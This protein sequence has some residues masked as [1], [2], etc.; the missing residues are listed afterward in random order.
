MEHYNIDC[1]VFKR[2][3][4]EIIAGKKPETKQEPKE[5]QEQILSKEGDVKNMIRMIETSKLSPHPD[6][7]RRDLGDL[8][9]L[10][11]SIKAKGILQNLTVVPWFSKITGVGCDD[12]KQQ[13]EMGYTCVI[14][15][16]RLAAAKL[17]GI[18]EVPCAVVD[19]RLQDQIA[20]M[21][22]E[23]IQRID[24]TVY[25]QAMGFQMMMDLGDTVTN[26][27][28]KTGFS[29]TTVRRRVKLLELDQEKFKESV[30]RGATLMDYAEL[31]KIKDIKLRNKVLDKIG[32]ENFRYELQRAIDKE[33]IDKRNALLIEQLRT[34]ATETKDTKELSYVRGFHD[35]EEGDIV[36][37]PEDAGAVKYF[38]DVGPYYVALYKERG[39]KEENTAANKQQKAMQEKKAA[40]TEMSNRAYQLR[41]DFIKN[42]S[43]SKAKKNIG[44]I[45]ENSLYATVEMYSSIGYKDFAE[46]FD[47]KFEE[48][49]YEPEYK[50][51]AEYIRKQPELYLLA[52]TWLSL[53]SD[54]DSYFDW[55]CAHKEN[56]DL[57]RVYDMLEV[58]GYE[59]SDEERALRDGT[60]ELFESNE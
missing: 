13:E 4:I 36:E 37:K 20:T 42:I 41:R 22:L 56:E 45:I 29:E 27:S 48:E 16:R 11:E 17:A 10:A 51:L 1:E 34:F 43:N 8:T 15:H 54:N 14:G 46:L 49:E 9:E 53:D 6:N 30:T 58:L 55:R 60:H 35:L 33:K 40:L 59:L 3:A 32:T 44:I 19:M 39:Q 23:N 5:V 50:D 26:I 28:E 24:L 25:E 31:E 52:A 38:Y 12:P 2:L 57:D 47:I 18:K 21:L 7:P